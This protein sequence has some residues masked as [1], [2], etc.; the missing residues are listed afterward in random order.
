[1]SAELIKK[2]NNVVDLQIVVSKEEFT[3][4]INGA[5][6]KLKGRFNV[7]GFR[8]GKA[9][10]KLIEMNYG[11]GVFVEEAINMVFPFAYRKAIEELNLSPI[12]MPNITDVKNAEEGKDLEMTVQVTV[13]PEFELGEYKGVEAEK[14][15]VEVSEDLVEKEIEAKRESN[16][17]FV[18]VEDR[19]VKNQDMT[20][21]DFEGFVD[22][23]AFEGGK[24]DNY[25]LV[26]GSN[27]FIPGFE[28]QLIG[29]EIGKEVEVNVEFPESY[30]A[31]NLAG[32]PAV[33][34]VTVKEIKEKELPNLDDEFVKDISE[35]DTLDE[36][37]AD[38]RAKL[39][40]DAKKT[41]ESETRKAVVEKVLENTEVEIPAAMVKAETEAMLKDFDMQL[42][43]QGLNLEQYMSLI[44]KQK[45]DLEEEMKEDAKNTVK[46]SLVLEKISEVEKI[47]VSNEEFEDY[48]KEMAE[49][50]KMELDKFKQN[51]NEEYE[52]NIKHSLVVK[53]T[54]DMLVENAKL[55]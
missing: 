53:K 42:R 3:K 31:D 43:Y 20:V 27:T 17:R 2:E 40:E 4:A 5:Y 22:G 9:P 50:Y 54:V 37:K 11:K 19:A 13:K 38:V 32:K 14:I 49:S 24:S 30:H 29:A 7:P 6:N 55:A 15:T 28:E 8:K 25:N 16:A 41:S 44:G 36:L 52:E 18:K 39:E 21:I 10:K 23:V 47:E 26:I 46:R 51:L 33:F 1:M 35:F 45:Q 12:E 48:I 34:K